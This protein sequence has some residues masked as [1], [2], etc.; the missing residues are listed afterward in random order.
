VPEDYPNRGGNSTK[1]Q[2]VWPTKEE[3]DKGRE[4]VERYAP[5]WSASEALLIRKPHLGLIVSIKRIEHDEMYFRLTVAVE[6]IIVAPEKFDPRKPVILQ[7]VWNAPYMSLDADSI[8][9]PY[10]FYLHFGAEGVRLVRKFSTTRMFHAEKPELMLGT[11]RHCFSSD[12]AMLK[13]LFKD[14]IG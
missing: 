14:E 4:A 12:P 1:L 8:S 13:A 9:A 6:E 11:L 2:T 7:C 5:Y 3:R 10:N